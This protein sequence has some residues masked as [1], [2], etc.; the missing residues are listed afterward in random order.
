MTVNVN[1]GGDPPESLSQRI[2]RARSHRAS[3][4]GE[5]AISELQRALYLDPYSVEARLELAAVYREMGDV[6]KAIVELRVALWD[7]EDAST[8]FL[9]A[10][11]Y[12]ELGNEKAALDHAE[13]ALTL[14]PA[15]SEARRLLETLKDPG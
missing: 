1:R 14:D 5:K 11:S 13:T 3:G 12:A 7:Q 2:E 15:S 6:E 8:H 4:L 9:L 10:E